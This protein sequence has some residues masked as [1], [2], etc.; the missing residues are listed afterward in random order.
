V[1]LISPLLLILCLVACQRG[2]QNNSEAVRQAVVDR[3]AQQKMDLAAMDIQVGDV[4]YNGEQAD[5]NVTITLKGKSDAPPMSF[6]YHL[7]RQ[8]N[9]WVA[10]GLSQ[11]SNHGGAADPN[12]AANPHGGA[13]PPAADGAGNPHGGMAPAGGGSGMPSPQDLP[14]ATKK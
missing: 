10:V 1:R 9:K 13:M 11:A 8:Q 3:L 6:R 4:Q 5:A 7:E 2:G 14:P 12:A